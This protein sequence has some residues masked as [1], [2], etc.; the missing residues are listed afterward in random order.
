MNK[1]HILL[2]SNEK[3]VTF[4]PFITSLYSS[5]SQLGGGNLGPQG[6][7]GNQCLEKNL[8]TRLGVGSAPSI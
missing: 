2:Q 6:T 4:I 8:V 5:G 7:F 3:H 1:S